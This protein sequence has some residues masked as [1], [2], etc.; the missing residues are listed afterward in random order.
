M[1]KILGVMA[2]LLLC[3]G[4]FRASCVQAAVSPFNLTDTDGDGIPDEWEASVYH[5][6]PAK[7]DTDGDGFSDL[8]EILTQNNSLGKGP[9][10][11]ADFD[12][13]GLNDRLELLFGTDPTKADTDGDGKLDGQE[14]VAGFSP[15]STSSIPLEKKILVHLSTQKLEQ[16]LAGITLETY[17]V[18]TGK[19]STPTP[20]GTFT[21]FYKNPRAWSRSAGLWMP[22]FMEFT[23]QGAGLHELPEWPGGK[24]EGAN[25]L[26]RP[27]SHGCIRL[28]IGAAKTL[29]DWAPLGTKV[30][31]IR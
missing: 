30:V 3:V 14:I 5:T 20:K 2:F 25:H 21:I 29:Y 19:P 8:T 7:V 6:D 17:T 16:Q 1:K 18:S 15:T 4:M 28:G 9:Y 24:K 10:I 26:G 27:V 22:W 31:A 13:D 23:K 12:K 11:P